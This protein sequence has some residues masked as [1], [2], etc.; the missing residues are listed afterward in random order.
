MGIPMFREP[1]PTEDAR[2]HAAKDSCAAARSAIRRQAS[3]RRPSR[4]GSVLRNATLRTIS[5]RSLSEELEM[6]LDRTNGPGLSRRNR[7]PNIVRAVAVGEDVDRARDR[8]AIGIQRHVRSPLSNAAA[9]EDPFDLTSGLLDSSRNEAGQRLLSDALRHGRP[10]QRLRIPRISAMADFQRRAPLGADTNNGPDPDHPQFTPRF[11]PAV[12]YHRTASPQARR[13]PHLS[14][15]P[16]SDSLGPELSATLALPSLRRMGQRSINDANRANQESAIDGLGDR[17]RSLSPDEDHAN[18][19]WETLLTTIT[20]DTNLPSA[21]SSFNSASASGTSAPVTVNGALRS[22]ATALQLAPNTMY[23]GPGP[24]EVVLDPYPEYLNPCDFPAS[25]LDSESDSD[26]ETSQNP[27]FRRY[28]AVRQMESVRRAVDFQGAMARSQ[29]TA[30]RAPEVQS[31]MSSQ[32]TVSFAFSDSSTDADL[33]QFQAVLDRLTRRQDLPDDFWASVGLSRTLA[34][35]E[36]DET[37]DADTVD[38]P[39]RPN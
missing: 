7:L 28:R 22:S 37:H 10:G 15:F 27:L 35:R 13:D 9:A 24:M 30:R 8:E 21:D 34:Q 29:G 20:P 2:N 26:S 18:D 1:S 5:P 3:V 31:T 23:S 38:G 16:L 33:H 32:P 17:Q 4:Y 11:A 19:A 36:N 12:A 25:A 14:P 39:L 6:E